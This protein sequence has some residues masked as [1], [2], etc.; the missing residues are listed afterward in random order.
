MSTK[1]KGAKKRF[2][3]SREVLEFR[4]ELG[5]IEPDQ[6]RV[7]QDVPET[8][9][10]RTLEQQIERAAQLID[11]YRDIE[12]LVD[13]AQQ[14]VDA[15]VGDFT[16]YLDSKVDRN[17]IEALKRKFPGRDDYNQISYADYRKCLDCISEH[18][19]SNVKPVTQEDIDAAKLD[20][21]KTSFAGLDL[22]PGLNRPELDPNSQL[23]EQPDMDAIQS[24][25]LKKLFDLLTPDIKGLISD[26][27]T[28]GAF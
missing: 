20:P 27:A 12:M 11:S 5:F 25:Q 28:G 14:R 6:L 1:T 17:T 18:A 3:P 26:A 9:A 24:S 16:V 13:V 8:E 23:V 4:P 2:A 21:L 7:P 22:P 15:R 19:A 10:P